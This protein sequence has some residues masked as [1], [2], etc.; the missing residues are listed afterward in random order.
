[1]SD[2]QQLIGWA[3]VVGIFGI[4]LAL[5]GMLRALGDYMQSK[6]DAALWQRRRNANREPRL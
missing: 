3:F 5:A 4:C 1:M 6:R 2:P